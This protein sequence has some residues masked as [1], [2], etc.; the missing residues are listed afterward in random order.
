MKIETNLFASLTRHKPEGIG[1]DSWMVECEEGTTVSTLLQEI[2]VPQE[3]VA[4]IF[5]NGVH[6]KMESV[7]ND[8]DR[9]GVFPPV[10]GG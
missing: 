1:T 3:E 2:G 9:L 10:G 8:M 5:I 7:L 4:L 6:G